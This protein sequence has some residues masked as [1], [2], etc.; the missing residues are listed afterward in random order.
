MF[1]LATISVA[2]Y[3]AVL[4]DAITAIGTALPGIA[5]AAIAIAVGLLF[6]GVG[7]KVI[8]RFAKS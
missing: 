3:T 4:T 6:L 5:T 1:S 7:F 2:A 8:R